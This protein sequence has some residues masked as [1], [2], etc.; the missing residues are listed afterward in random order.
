V[1]YAVTL[2]SAV[3]FTRFG[4]RVSSRVFVEAKN[5][6]EAKLIG[7]MRIAQEEGKTYPIM[8]VVEMVEEIVKK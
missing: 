8:G 1:K 6:E 2:Q 7:H 4:N 3:P 5:E